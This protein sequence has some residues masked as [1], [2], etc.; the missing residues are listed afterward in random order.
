MDNRWDVI[1]DNL[2]RIKKL[3]YSVSLNWK[4]KISISFEDYY[5]PEDW[6]TNNN[7]GIYESFDILNY[8]YENDLIDW[9]DAVEQVIDIFYSWYY[10]NG[11]KL[12]N[13]IKQGVRLDEILESI[14]TY[15]NLTDM[16][17][18]EISIKSILGE[19]KK[20]DF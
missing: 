15:H 8:D 20:W 4:E 14:D 5:V 10:E 17:N 6:N 19:N 16:V 3:G 11:I 9:L 18:R 1:S 13:L 7:P 2:D 12:N